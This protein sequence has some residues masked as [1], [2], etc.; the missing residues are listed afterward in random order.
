[1]KKMRQLWKKSGLTLVLSLLFCLLALPVTAR[2]AEL[3]PTGDPENV[4]DAGAGSGLQGAKLGTVEIRGAGEQHIEWKNPDQR[5]TESGGHQFLAVRHGD[6]RYEEAE[7]Y[8]YVWVLPVEKLAVTNPPYKTAYLLGENFE[9]TGMKVTAYYKAEA[10]AVAEAGAE[11]SYPYSRQLDDEEYIIPDGEN[12]PLAQTAVTVAAYGK[13]AAQP[14]SV[15]KGYTVKINGIISGHYSQ[16]PEYDKVNHT[17]IVNEREGSDVSFLFEQPEGATY[18]GI[19][20]IKGLTKEQLGLQVSPEHF[21]G[22]QAGFFFTM[23]ANDVEL[24]IQWS[25]LN[26]KKQET[27]DNNGGGSSSGG[28]GSSGSG[29]STPTASAP[30]PIAQGPK[31][32]D[33]NA[34]RTLGYTLLLLA[35]VTGVGGITLCR[36][37]R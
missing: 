3:A 24:T 27:P 15:S 23:P 30:Q 35:A 14:I 16:Y 31:T 17:L 1:M 12:L 18:E 28:S 6:N 9:E 33:T 21:A 8:I 25:G 29:S 22:G 19:S 34:V 5:M 20:I 26:D 11:E 4:L 7:G 13:T 37:K 10:E 36:R 32:A 2:A